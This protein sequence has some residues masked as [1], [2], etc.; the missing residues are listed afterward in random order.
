MRRFWMAIVTIS[1]GS[2]S[3]GRDVAE[4]VAQRLGYDCVGRE[5]LLEASQ[6]FNVPGAGL[7]EAVRVPPS[8]FD[9]LAERKKKYI[10]AIQVAFLRRARR[11]DIVYHGFA[12]HVFVKRV[13]H[14]V[15]VRVLADVEDRIQFV[16]ER[17]GK[18]WGEA[19]RFIEDLDEHRRNWSVALYGSDIR[20]PSLYDLVL[21]V[22]Q[23]TV[24]GAVELICRAVGL[25]EFQITPE[26]IQMVD[27]LALA[28]EVRLALSSLGAETMI[29]ATQGRVRVDAKAPRPRTD[30][31]TKEIRQVVRQVT[32]VLDLHVEVL[33]TA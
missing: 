33:P 28:A 9:P 14:A 12:G 19:A 30:A 20:N 10:A 3:R 21:H 16:M 25:P 26:S 4:K 18:S 6:Q 15:K 27:D 22:R 32:G 1:R 29:R 8:S 11:N 7:M 31:I 17:D 13:S 5:V 24:E 23:L 2:F